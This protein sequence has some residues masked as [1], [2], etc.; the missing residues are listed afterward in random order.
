[1][2]F[3]FIGTLG[4][5]LASMFAMRS[6]LDVSYIFTWD[7]MS[8]ILIIVVLCWLPFYV[9]NIVYKRYFPEAHERV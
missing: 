4:L 7:T 5:Y 8:S 6:V 1:M 3:S 2:L 9:V